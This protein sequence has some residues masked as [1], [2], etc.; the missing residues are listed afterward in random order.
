MTQRV[1]FNPKR[2]FYSLDGQYVPSVTTVLN[3]A[4][5]KPQLL[6]WAARMAAQWC[7]DNVD[8]LIPMGTETWVETAVGAADR[9]RDAAAKAGSQ[10]HTVAERL[11]YGEPIGEADETG[12]PLAPEV[13]EMATH[14]ARFMDRRG[15]EPVVHEA[16]VFHE[17]HKWAGTLD[18]I[19]DLGDGHRWLLDY[20]TSAAGVYP[21]AALQVTAYRHATHI[22][23][24]EQV[25][26][27]PPVDGGGVIW[28]RPDGCQL[29]PVNADDRQ[30]GWFMH[31]RALAEWCRMK[32]EESVY[33]PL[34][35]WEVS[36]DDAA[37]AGR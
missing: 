2:H 7:A 12:E 33:A 11:I 19:A 20:K 1:V 36:G 23:V 22:Q 9:H 31:A 10:L 17:T 34:P 15:V 16:I 6:K 27:M 5:A 3:R 29:V 28:V 25:L 21:E 8:G 14:L 18:V 30:Y 32:P 13:R 35:E 37:T 4:I 24:G 26:L